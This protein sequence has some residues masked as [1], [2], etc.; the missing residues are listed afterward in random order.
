MIWMKVFYSICF[1]EDRCEVIK[2][3]END[4][5]TCNDL[6]EI[7]RH[8]LECQFQNARTRDS[9]SIGNFL[10]MPSKIPRCWIPLFSKNQINYATSQVVHGLPTDKRPSIAEKPLK[11]AIAR[12]FLVSLAAVIRVVTQC[13]SSVA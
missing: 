1:P 4:V 9:K 2:T 6:M 5:A 13:F 3:D 10:E 11:P 12:C 7:L 8:K